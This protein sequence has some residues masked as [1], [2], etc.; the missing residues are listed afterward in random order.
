[1][2]L[3]ALSRKISGKLSPNEYWRCIA[4]WLR[5]RGDSVHVNL[6]ELTLKRQPLTKG[7][8]S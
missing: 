6:F 2:T 8:A 1:M 4:M 3:K 5:M 7:P